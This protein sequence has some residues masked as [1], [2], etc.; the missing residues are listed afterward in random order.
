MEHQSWILTWPMSLSCS[1]FIFFPVRCRCSC[2]GSG[3]LRGLYFSRS[4]GDIEF[5]CNKDNQY[6]ALT[7]AGVFNKAVR[8]ESGYDFYKIPYRR[9]ERD[10]IG[11][12]LARLIRLRRFAGFIRPRF[13]YGP[14]DSTSSINF[15][16]N[17]IGN[18]GLLAADGMVARTD[19]G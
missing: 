4:A 5:L 18:E 2:C 8:R 3:V 17:R 10:T 12:R 6:S 9:A 15:H 1:F 7:S 13:F 16:G 11:S 19:G 14:R